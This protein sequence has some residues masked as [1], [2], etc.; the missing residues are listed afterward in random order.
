MEFGIEKCVVQIMSS[1]KRQMV[2]VI[3]LPNQEKKR[4]LGE[5]GL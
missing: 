1:R 2:E 4:K 5:K 3:E